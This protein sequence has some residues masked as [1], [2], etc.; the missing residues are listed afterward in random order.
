MLEAV[1]RRGGGRQPVSVVDDL[2]DSCVPVF[3]GPFLERARLLK[4]LLAMKCLKFERLIL[5]SFG[6]S[7]PSVAGVLW[8][9]L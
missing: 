6:F 7:S 1:A 8:L 2:G 5:D 9:G 4:A 3:R